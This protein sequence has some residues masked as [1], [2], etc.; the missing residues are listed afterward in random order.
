[1]SPIERTQAACGTTTRQPF[2]LE[3][4][5]E[6]L[7]GGSHHVQ[8]G[9]CMSLSAADRIIAPVVFFHLALVYPAPGLDAECF[10]AVLDSTLAHYPALCGR[11]ATDEVRARGLGAAAA[12]SRWG[13][14]GA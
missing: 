3:V 12:V 8:H 6:C 2:V 11:L 5:E 14:C 4:V 13:C 7:C 1:M 10:R 9:P